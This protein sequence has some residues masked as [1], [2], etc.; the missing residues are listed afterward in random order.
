MSPS[1]LR[2]NPTSNGVRG[3]TCSQ[4][5]HPYL[6]EQHQYTRAASQRVEDHLVR[7]DEEIARLASLVESLEAQFSD[8]IA[9]HGRSYSSTSHSRS[10][11]SDSPSS[12]ELELVASGSGTGHDR[13]DRASNNVP[14]SD[15]D[16]SLAAKWYADQTSVKV[17]ER[18][19]RYVAATLRHV[20]PEEFRRRVLA[21]YR[22][23]GHERDLLRDIRR[24]DWD[25]E[26]RDGSP[27]EE[28]RGDAGP[29]DGYSFDDLEF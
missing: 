2:G 29:A 19:R 14:V 27:H 28:D 11:S 9:T 20:G 21:L 25:R 16:V 17:T 13:R 3:D 15:D 4:Q 10:S 6:A 24:D 18:K 5:A 7:Q 26:L 23:R 1:D 8:P 22:L 12:K